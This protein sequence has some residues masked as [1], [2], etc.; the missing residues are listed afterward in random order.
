MRIP[1]EKFYDVVNE[2]GTYGQV[3][4]KNISAQDVTKQV[5]GTGAITG[6]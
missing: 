4:Q 6:T 2:L 3:T 1:A 5:T